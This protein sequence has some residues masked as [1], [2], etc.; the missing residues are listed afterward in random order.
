MAS[1]KSPNFLSTSPEFEIIKTVI[2][3][4]EILNLQNNL[5]SMNGIMV[6]FEFLP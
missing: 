3:T 2:K 4:G 6:I 1:S 5:S